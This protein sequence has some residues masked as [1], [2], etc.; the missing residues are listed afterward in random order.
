M[1]V[2]VGSRKDPV[3]VILATTSRLYG[4]LESYYLLNDR[5]SV[6]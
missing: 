1:G 3:D 6:L 2:H 5:V 4:L